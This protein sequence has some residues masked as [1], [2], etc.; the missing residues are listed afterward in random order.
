VPVVAVAGRCLLDGAELADAGIRAAYALTDLEPD[1][2]RCMADAA[3]LLQRLSKRIARDWLTRTSTRSN[4]P[5]IDMIQ[6][7]DSS[8]CDRA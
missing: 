7:M 4:S 6:S 3:P 5:S 2:A 1:P 8:C